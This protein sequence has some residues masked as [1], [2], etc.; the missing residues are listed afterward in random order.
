MEAA[1]SFEMLID[2]QWK[3]WRYIPEYRILN[4]HRSENCKSC[5]V[6]AGLMGFA[7]GEELIYDSKLISKDYNG[8]ADST[9]YRRS[10]KKNGSPVIQ[11]AAYL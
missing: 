7:G 2:F 8:D 5:R 10:W 11:L 1:C 9:N 4:N 3:R 6:H